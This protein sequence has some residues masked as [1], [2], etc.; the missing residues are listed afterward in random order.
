MQQRLIRYRPSRPSASSRPESWD[1]C[2]EPPAQQAF[3]EIG[4]YRFLTGWACPNA[5][6]RPYPVPVPAPPGG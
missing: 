3:T 2:D 4:S 1:R 6:T 5:A